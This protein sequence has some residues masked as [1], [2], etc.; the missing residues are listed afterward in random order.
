MP[1]TGTLTA[2]HTLADLIHRAIREDAPPVITEGGMIREGYDAELDEL[3]RISQDGKGWLAK[4]EAARSVDA[5]GINSL[6]GSLQQGFR[7]LHRG[8]PHPQRIGARSLCAQTD[9][10]QCGALHHR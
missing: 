6:K 8:F 4:L 7:L 9:P 3:I 10:G 1:T 2:L 5:T